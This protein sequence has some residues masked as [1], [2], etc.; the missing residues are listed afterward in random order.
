MRGCPKFTVVKTLKEMA[1]IVTKAYDNDEV[2]DG[3]VIL[4]PA[5]R[6]QRVYYQLFD[7]LTIYR[8][9]PGSDYPKGWL[10][11]RGGFP[12]YMGYNDIIESLGE[13]LGK[14]ARMINWWNWIDFADFL[15]ITPFTSITYHVFDAHDVKYEIS[16]KCNV[17]WVAPANVSMT[18]FRIFEFWY[19]QRTIE[20]AGV[21]EFPYWNEYE[22]VYE[23]KIG[24]PYERPKLLIREL[25][26][27]VFN[28]PN[29][30]KYSP[31]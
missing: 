19:S 1:E 3:F 18:K 24:N 26:K 11:D 10:P 27:F 14:G 17:L 8:I 16:N 28:D 30:I 15:D 9:L 23:I 4:D 2:H 20:I 7:P 29:V 12:Y 21:E 5:E 6:V 31:I 25:S 22:L 13:W